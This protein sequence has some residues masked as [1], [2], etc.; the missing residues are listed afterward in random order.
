[1][2]DFDES[3]EHRQLRELV[4][5]ITAAH[6]PAEYADHARRAAPEDGLWSDLGKAGCIGINVPEEYGG[7]GA[8]MQEL[9][10]VATESAAAGC[11][12]LLL[13]VS[14]A[15]GVE[16]LRRHGSAEQR[17]EW[18]PRLADGSV[19]LSFA[20]TEP[21][22][23]SNSHRIST[24]AERDGADYVIT[25]GKYYISG[26]DQSAAVLTVAR[27]GVD[28]D[29]GRGRLTLFLVPTDTP[30]LSWTAIDVAA[31]IPDR[32]FTVHFDRVRVPA[33]A[34]VGA[35]NDLGPL[36]DG[37]N[38]ER[39]TAAAIAVG[40]GRFVLSA[41]AR[42]VSDR[43][44]W[45]VPT[46]AHQA[47]AHPLARAKVEVEV[48]AVATARAAWLHDAGRPAGEAANMAKFAAAE[49]A[50]HAVDAAIQA[51]GGNG[52]SA[53]FGLLPMWGMARLLRIAPVSSEMILNYVA[54][55]SLGLPRSY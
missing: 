19:K 3:P 30:G 2:P 13:L 16:V 52:L 32:Q 24:T 28:A 50:G 14:S 22:A 39:I 35:P 43:S 46:G 5:D 25:G 21:D 12:L 26:I 10:L 41:A 23:G 42:Y 15:I 44:V 17:Q 37:L 53:D 40:I 11:P 45:G 34:V 20:I 36:F 4:R 38:P 9:A 54:Q 33:S 27:T 51:H 1:M 49:A 6:G 8:G 47:V 18:L 55:H 48:A 31:Q 7:G 29:T